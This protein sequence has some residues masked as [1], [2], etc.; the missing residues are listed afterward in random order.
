MAV[1]AA[2]T[3]RQVLSEEPRLGFGVLYGEQVMAL[4]PVVSALRD[5]LPDLVV[6]L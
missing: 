6:G 2:E 1:I 5:N 3:V 4:D